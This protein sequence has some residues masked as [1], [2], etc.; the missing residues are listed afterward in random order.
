[1]ALGVGAFVTHAYHS[2]VNAGGVKKIWFRFWN[3]E[4]K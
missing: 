4:T 2:I 3:G 1:V